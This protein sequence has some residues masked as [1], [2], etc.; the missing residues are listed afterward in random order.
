MDCLAVAMQA[1][2]Q[3]TQSRSLPH[4]RSHCWT[5]VAL[6]TASRQNFFHVQNALENT[7]VETDAF[8]LKAVEGLLSV[9]AAWQNNE[10]TTTLPQ[11]PPNMNQD[12]K[13]T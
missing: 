9:G 4:W 5:V 13:T 1:A 7:M 12:S 11:Q 6:G 3:Q 2:Q 10:L 8:K